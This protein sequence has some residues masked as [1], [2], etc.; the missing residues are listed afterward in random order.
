[1]LVRCPTGSNVASGD[2]AL[3]GILAQ[4]V[5][6]QPDHRDR[7]G[8]DG[9]WFESQPRSA[10]RASARRWR[11]PQRDSISDSP[12]RMSWWAFQA[13]RSWFN[14]VSK[15]VLAEEKSLF[16]FMS[17]TLHQISLRL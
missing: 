1:M 7:T 6:C 10:D 9:R 14:R 12:K 17:I 3:L 8:R 15:L 16:N 4:N 13:A 5:A 11:E 2:I